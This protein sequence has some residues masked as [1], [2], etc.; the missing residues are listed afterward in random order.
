[1]KVIEFLDNKSAKYEISQ[2]RPT[3][4]AQQMAAEEHVPGMTVA[5]PVVIQADDE[6]YMCVLPACCKVDLDKLK[7][8]LKVKKLALATE[9]QM[10]KVFTDCELGAE[11]PFGHLYGLKT[12]MDETLQA[13]EYIVFQAGTHDKAVKMAMTDY[14]KLAEPKIMS[15]SYR[16]K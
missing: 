5:K 16:S 7:K 4:T 12:V 13:D 14:Q 8:V 9:D 11:P 6:Y 10:A 3:F 15:F 1:M 2:H